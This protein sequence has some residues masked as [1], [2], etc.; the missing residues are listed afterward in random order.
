MYLLE[1]IAALGPARVVIVYHPYYEGFAAWARQV[2][3]EHGQA[4][5]ERAAH[6]DFGAVLQPCLAV[7]FVPQQGPYADLTSVINGADHLAC[8]AELYVAF[9]YNL[10]GKPGPLLALRDAAPGQVAV[11]ARS[12]RPELAASRGVI[13]TTGKPGQRLMIGLAEKPGPARARAMERRYGHGNLFLLDGRARLTAAFVQ[14]AR[15]CTAA[16]PHRA[17]TSADHRGLRH[18]TS[19]P[20]HR[21]QR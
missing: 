2:L 17:E 16:C 7:S 15:I 19:G 5:Y 12:Y 1:E 18:I 8:P 11:L 21:N 13:A 14:F 4:R 9:A 20:H 3:S 10:Y 6:S